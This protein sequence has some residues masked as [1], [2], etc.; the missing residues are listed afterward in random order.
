MMIEYAP[1][2]L[3][4]FWRETFHVSRAHP[5]AMHAKAYSPAALQTRS[6]CPGKHELGHRG[7]RELSLAA[8]SNYL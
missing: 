3:V 6:P 5:N 1:A 8:F 7:S 2:W 4:V